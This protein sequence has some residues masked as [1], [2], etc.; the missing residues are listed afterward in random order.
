MEAIP[1]CANEREIPSKN[2][3]AN[4]SNDHTFAA[5]TLSCPVKKMAFVIVF[6]TTYIPFVIL[7][8]SLADRHA[9]RALRGPR[10]ER[11]VGGDGAPMLSTRRP[12]SA[13]VSSR[14][15]STGR[16]RT[17]RQDP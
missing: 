10:F 14:S 12:A 16:L 15:L 4:S 17:D 3:Q 11:L 9:M 13:Y 7:M 8:L 2:E 6:W 5:D 1:N